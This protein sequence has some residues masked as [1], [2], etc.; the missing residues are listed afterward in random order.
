MIRP[1]LVLAAATALAGCTDS[2]RAR[3]S[4]TWQD[5]PA[6]IT[7]RSYGQVIFQ[8]RSTGKVEYD[9]GGRIS[10][11]DASNGRLTAVEGECL[12]VYATP[13]PGE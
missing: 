13:R 8:G 10:F 6:D 4:A 5:M 12:V 3:R 1:L 2:E 9:E 7:C 11:V